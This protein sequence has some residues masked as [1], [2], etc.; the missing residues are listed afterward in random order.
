MIYYGPQTR[1]ARSTYEGVLG[2]GV[3]NTYL[4]GFRRRFVTLLSGPPDLNGEIF[5][6]RRRKKKNQLGGLGNKLQGAPASG[7]LG[8]FLATSTQSDA[9][10]LPFFPGFQDLQVISAFWGSG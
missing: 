9:G 5:I 8:S 6:L 3:Q 2:W 7:N 4:L 1:I 10:I